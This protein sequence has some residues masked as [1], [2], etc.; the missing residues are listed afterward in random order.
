[1]KTILLGGPCDGQMIDVSKAQ[2]T[3]VMEDG[4]K[5]YRVMTEHV[6]VFASINVVPH[7]V[8]PLIAQK[9][10]ELAELKQ[11]VAGALGGT[12]TGLVPQKCQHQQTE[13]R[14][15]YVICSDCGHIKTDGGWGVASRQW[16]ESK[17]HAKFYEKNGRL[18]ET[19]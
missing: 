19:I 8:Y 6:A 18:P 7:D 16:F 2:C 9:L 11:Q 10:V 17:E 12:E 13:M 4:H 1:M 15:D 14:Y 3:W 5:Y